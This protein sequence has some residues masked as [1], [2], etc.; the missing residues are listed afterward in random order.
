M[1]LAGRLGFDGMKATEDGVETWC[2][3]ASPDQVKLTSNTDPTVSGD[4]RYSL[5]NAG[6]DGR[7][8]QARPLA[9]MPPE[10]TPLRRGVA[11][12]RSMG[13]AGSAR[14]WVGG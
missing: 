8:A 3:I 1:D 2:A 7:L 13:A 12:G 11:V 9:Q 10:R 4:V 14:V 5:K 6:G